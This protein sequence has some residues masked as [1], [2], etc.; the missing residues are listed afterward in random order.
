MYKTAATSAN[1]LAP[2]NKEVPAYERHSPRRRFRH[3]A[4][5]DY[6]RRIQATAAYLRQADDL[7]SLVRTDVGR[8]PRHPADQHP[9]RHRRLSASAGRWLRRSEERRVGEE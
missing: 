5:P 4:V 7:L 9:G 2:Q 1:V 8:Y 3:S 6:Q